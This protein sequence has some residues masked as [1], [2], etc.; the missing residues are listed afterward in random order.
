VY[1][2]KTK[3][4]QNAFDGYGTGNNEMRVEKRRCV[5]IIGADADGA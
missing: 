4:E 1:A 3:N 2:K 5:R